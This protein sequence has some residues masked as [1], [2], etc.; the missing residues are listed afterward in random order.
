MIL[1]EDIV[2]CEIIDRKVYLHLAS[3][4]IVD[5]YGRIEKLETNVILHYMK[6]WRL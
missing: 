6:E 3:S 4:E 5:F 2:Y 1:F